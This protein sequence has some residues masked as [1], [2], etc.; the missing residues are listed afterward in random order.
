M[1]RDIKLSD[2]FRIGNRTISLGTC[3]NRN[4]KQYHVV[5]SES[6][7]SNTRSIIYISKSK[8]AAA[9]HFDKLK[10]LD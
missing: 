5:L 8:D 9:N 7:N 10:S 3:F 2:S 1:L 6:D 4:G